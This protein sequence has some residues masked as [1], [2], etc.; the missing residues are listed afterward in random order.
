MW[1]CVGCGALTAVLWVASGWYSFGARIY[2]SGNVLA[3]YEREGSIKAVW[4]ADGSLPGKLGVR[5]RWIHEE[6]HGGWRG[7]WN[8]YIDPSN[9]DI[10]IPGW[11]PPLLF[12]APAALCFRLSRRPIPGLCPRCGYDRSGV[13]AGV[14]P[15]CG[16]AAEP[17]TTT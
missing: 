8:W 4:I 11:F 16:A 10:G 7:E 2:S 5:L 12:L 17:D 14:C 3:V 9:G 15:E 6:S 1:A 13:P